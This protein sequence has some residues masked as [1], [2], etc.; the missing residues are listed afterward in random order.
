M[1]TVATK[2]R[3]L[4]DLTHDQLAD[5]N[6]QIVQGARR[7]CA[8]RRRLGTC[9]RGAHPYIWTG[10]TPGE[11]SMINAKIPA[12]LPDWV[13]DHIRRYVATDGADGHMMIL[14][15][16]SSRTRPDLTLGHNRPLLRREIR[17]PADL[18]RDRRQLCRRRL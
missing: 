11:I 10:P 18:R 3:A 1:P 17:L 4:N 13:K 15:N 9:G 7:R 6:S 14:A 8:C 16:N 2:V 12:T 5:P